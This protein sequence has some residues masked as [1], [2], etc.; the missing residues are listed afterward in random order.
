MLYQS[1][2]LSLIIQII[3][4]S[5][6]IFGLTI[7]IQKDKLLFNQLLKMEFS[8]QIVELIFY[9]WM[10]FNFSSIDNIT[11]KR[12]YDWIIT[13]PIMLI[14]LMAYLDSRQ[15]YDIFAFISANKNILIKVVLANLAMLLF[16]LLGEYGV[17]DYNIAILMGFIPFIYYFYLIYQNYIRDKKQT[18]DKKI[19][20]LFFFI[21]WSIY[22]LAAF[23]PYIIKNTAYNIL[24]LF[25]KNLFGVFLVY[26]IW[27]FRIK[28]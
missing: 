4:L 9:V 11:P 10:I 26:L 28:K 2:I 27:T 25:A 16:G 6:D 22:G 14:T 1:A 7:P 12:Y 24:D 8:V 13:T 3:V 15:F 23:F 18:N 19:V 5:V 20:F 17:I 21:I